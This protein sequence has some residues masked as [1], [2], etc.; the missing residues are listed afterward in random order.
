MIFIQYNN[1]LKGEDID[2]SLD[3]VVSRA[4]FKK[5][6]ALFLKL[7]G[8]DIEYDPKFKLFLQTKLTNPHYKPEVIF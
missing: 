6:R 1:L 8:E 3:P 4:M 5:G 2:A 7:G